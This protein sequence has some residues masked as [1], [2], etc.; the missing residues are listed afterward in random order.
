[1]ENAKCSSL[2]VQQLGQT[3]VLS[4]RWTDRSKPKEERCVAL[5]CAWFDFLAEKVET[6]ASRQRYAKG[7]AGFQVMPQRTNS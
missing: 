5:P 7:K 6:R 3:F 2:S 1:M 4:S